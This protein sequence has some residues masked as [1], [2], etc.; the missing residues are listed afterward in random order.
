MTFDHIL[1]L[2]AGIC[3]IGMGF[4]IRK[5]NPNGKWKMLIIGG[6]IFLVLGILA[7]TFGWQT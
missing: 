7:V 4:Q 2:V 3:L 1:T 5:E 6:L